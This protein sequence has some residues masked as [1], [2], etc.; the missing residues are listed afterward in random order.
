MAS[1]SYSLTRG[2]EIDRLATGVQ[3]V[4]A[5]TAVPGAGD[6]EVRINL[7]KNFTKLEVEQA[8]ETIWRFIENPDRDTNFPL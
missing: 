2:T 8:L 6:I 5:G 1:V 7:A 4:T 3:T